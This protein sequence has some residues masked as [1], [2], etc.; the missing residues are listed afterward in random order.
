MENIKVVKDKKELEE[1]LQRFDKDENTL[2]YNKVLHD[3]YSLDFNEKI[4]TDFYANDEQTEV[5]QE[6][7]PLEYVKASKRIINEYYSEIAEFVIAEPYLYVSFIIPGIEQKVYEIEIY[8]DREPMFE[9]QYIQTRLSEKN[10][11]RNK[12]I[13][14][15]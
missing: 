15:K 8:V 7:I 9:S 12:L 14:I 2:I 11:T 10:I 5:S 3:N 1:F 6:Y 13:K 4:S